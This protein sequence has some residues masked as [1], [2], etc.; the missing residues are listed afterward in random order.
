MFPP[1]RPTA[2][3]TPNLSW[4][5]LFLRNSSGQITGF[6]AASNADNHTLDQLTRVSSTEVRLSHYR[7]YARTEAMIPMR[8]GTHLHAVIFRPTPDLSP[9]Q[10]PPTPLPFLIDRTPYGVDDNTSESINRTKPELAASG[11]IFVFQD[12]RGRYKSEGSFV[13]NR[14]L[15]PHTTP[16]AIDETTDT[17]DTVAWLLKNIPGNNGRAGVLGVSYDGFLAMMAG[18]D[19]HPAI[20]A[21]SPQAP[22]T[23]VWLGDDFFHN[24]AF[25]QSYAFDYVQQ[26]E[27]QKTDAVVNMHFGTAK[28]DAYDFF[29][30][31]ANFAN[32]AAFAKIADLPTAKAFLTQPTYTAFWQAMAVQTHLAQVTV[33]TL[34]VGGFWDQ[35][36]M[37]GTQAEYAAM[38]T[39]TTPTS[40]SSSAPG[41][42]A[43]GNTPHAPSAPTSARSTSTSPPA[44]S[45]ASSSKLPSSKNISKTNPAS[46]SPT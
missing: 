40:S 3:D 7:N 37:Y 28:Q 35:E 44:P 30:E 39:T 15:V 9:Q 20:K 12:I 29:L 38:A 25:R 17:Y 43:A 5:L 10:T 33:P 4:H 23:D 19:P 36:D 13:M 21:I 16:T 31:H 42:T 32:A 6:R 27:A 2:F 46:T 45:T 14:P 8:D 22:M 18:I 24:G 1:P 11:Y 26:M 34:E 41:T